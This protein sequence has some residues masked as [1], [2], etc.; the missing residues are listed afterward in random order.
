MATKPTVLIVDDEAPIRKMINEILSLE[1]YPVESA[2]NGVEALDI[3]ARGGSRVVLL[4][5]KMPVMDG[6]EVM[7]HLQTTPDIRARN[8]VALLSA[9]ANLEA[10]ADLTADGKLAKPFTA[11]QLINIIETLGAGL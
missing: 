6:R 7:A 10:N 8:K 5:I 1:G 11:D 9:W 2:A 4:D 3:M